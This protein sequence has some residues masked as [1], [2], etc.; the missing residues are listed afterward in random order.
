MTES[1]QSF[2]NIV[3]FNYPRNAEKIIEAY[4]FAAKAHEG[5]TRKSGE[6]YIVHPLE[7]AKILIKNNMDYAT[8][9]AG[10]LH[11]V[12]EDTSFSLEDIKKMFGEA[13]AKLVDGVTKIDNLT[14]EKENLTEA[15]SIKRLI[16]AMGDDVRV[17]FIKLADR[18]HN[19]RTI[20]FLPREKQLKMATET[21]EL[22]IPIAERIGI[23]KIRSELQ[24]LVFKC[25]NPEEYIKIKT[26][27]DKKLEEEKLKIG[28]IE[29]QLSEYLVENGLECSV[30]GW[31]ERYYSIYKKMQ[32]KGMGK[33]FG[34]ILIKVIVPKEIDC[35]KALGYLHSK[36]DHIPSQIKDFISAPK[37]NGYKSLHTVLI[38]K[39]GDLM[40]KVMI[41]THAMDNVCEYGISCLWNNKDA[42]IDFF[43][44]FERF[45]VFKKIVLSE[46]SEINNADAFI[47]AIKTDLASK[48]TWV[49][50][51]NYRPI[52]LKADNPT[53]I[54]FAYALDTRVG[55][56]AISAVV[57]GKKASIG[58]EL[59]TGDVVEIVLSK[60]DKSPSR[61]WLFAIKTTEARR[62]IRE[63]FYKHTTKANIEL[64]KQELIDELQKMNHTLDDFLNNFSELKK[65]F[66][67]ANVNDM[68]ASLGYK[69]V[70]KN[71]LLKCMFIK[72]E[73]KKLLDNCP[74]EIE[75][76]TGFLNINFPKCCSA[77][78]G[79]DIVGV[80]SKN[81]V[82]IHTASCNNLSK[83]N[84]LIKFNA[85][86][87]EN[88][89]QTFNVNLKIVAKNKMGFASRLFNLIALENIDISKI[90]AKNIN[91]M[92][93]EFK[94]NIYIKNN[95]ELDRIF[96][97]ILSIEDVKLV[98]RIFE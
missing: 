88:I 46:K 32:T 96:K 45:N 11:D 35:Y 4:K 13:V 33:V 30:V 48:T 68:F 64:G 42:D 55:H 91:S 7:V 1:E 79:D 17:I 80:M 94:L 24:E 72:K 65:E 47:D 59:A 81:G 53:A 82:A 60:T 76:A 75:G 18:L 14:L 71:Q 6:P 86:W 69:S 51:S 44:K 31:P 21:N 43:E 74:V 50:T 97:T 19:M 73:Q 20:E 40:F 10:L 61:N 36:F 58:A 39:G 2:F 25:I 28:G 78:P 12:V 85:K 92:E 98:K 34:L 3:K 26:G 15:D 9:V 87:K 56:N 49:F 66:D 95:L 62:K 84:N 8:I 90:E 27:F 57:N 38:S 70:N 77:I 63:Y 41:R 93:C 5:I 67:F 16:I 89:E 54:D 37:P 52:C 23:R 29:R 83:I 22:F